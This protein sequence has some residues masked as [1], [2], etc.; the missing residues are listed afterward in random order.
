[1]NRKTIGIF[2]GLGPES[3]ASCYLRICR[4]YHEESGDL[5]YPE[6]VVF[7]ANFQEYIDVGYE[8]P[9][10]VLAAFEALARAGADFGVAA[11]NSVHVVYDQLQGRLPIPW[12]GV[13]DAAADAVLERGMKKVGL[14][15]TVFTMEKGFYQ[16]AFERRGL[17]MFV[18]EPAGRRRI[19]DIIYRELVVADVR[20]ESRQDALALVEGLARRGAEGVLLGCT[21][22]P[23]LLQDGQGPLPLFDTTDILARKALDVALGRK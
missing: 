15:G 11:C 8:A 23:F 3:T 2:G 10:K 13:M 17:E 6:T 19:N 16:S 7:S 21:E 4:A 5:A 20:E 22:L 12:V 1:M 14:L 18:P 9:E